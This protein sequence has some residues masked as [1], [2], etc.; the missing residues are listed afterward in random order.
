MRK[1]TPQ[2]IHSLSRH[3]QEHLGPD[4][5]PVTVVL[6]NIRSLHNVGSIFRT[7]DAARVQRLCLTGITGRPPRREIDKTALGAVE[8]V[9]WRYIPSAGEA[10]ADLK[11]QGANI[12]ILEQ[13]D[14]SIPLFEVTFQW[15]AALVLGNEVFGVDEQLF[16]L[17]DRCV[18]IPMFGEKH[19]L[20]VSVAAGIVLF[21]MVE[22]YVQQ[23]PNWKIAQRLSKR[24]ESDR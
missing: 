19:S 15:P 16:P 22:Q 3:T 12:Y 9:P 10:L 5:L 24:A 11:K 1:L 20:N 7:C 4:R 18:A 13:T 17:A 23:H 14:R 8:S 2:E 6:D 21:K